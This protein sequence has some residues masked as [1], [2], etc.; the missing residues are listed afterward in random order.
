[1]TSAPQA[2]GVERRRQLRQQRRQEFLRNIWR[3]L[4]LSGAAAGLGF[5]LLRQG[6]SLRQP[7]QVEVI[8]SE[9]VSR[10]QVIQAAALRFPVPLLEIDP[11]GLRTRLGEA[12]PVERVQVERLMLPPR[13][14]IELV[15]R[16][17]V[18][19]AERRT[20]E[21][22]EQGYVDRV[23][24]WISRSQQSVGTR[25]R[26]P[27]P[28]VRV[29]GW[30]ERHRAPLTQILARSESLGSPLREIRF[31]PGGTLWLVTASLGQVR[32]GPP[33]GQLN[34]RLDVLR[35]LSEQLPSRV[36][37]RSVQSVDLSD[38]DQPEL[39]LPPGTPPETAGNGSGG[40]PAE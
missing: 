6:W 26:N 33:D 21:G 27:E 10:D 28:A 39:G 11:R 9:R 5:V 30:Q 8:G 22:V 35:Y 19:R 15:D 2:P 16:Q 23:G 18:A 36:K 12:L 1:M 13:L 25:G 4:L 17:A 40:R 37:G 32:L 14:R 24:N 31:E 34:R 20:P 38:P 3:L 7:S 29:V